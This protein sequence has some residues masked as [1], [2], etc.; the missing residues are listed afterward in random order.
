M[1]I[2]KE[3]IVAPRLKFLPFGVVLDE[4]ADL[5]CNNRGSCSNTT[6]SEPMLTKK[7]NTTNYGVVRKAVA[8]KISDRAKKIL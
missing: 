4:S 1:K 7:R 2:V 5:H 8:R 6:N 3:V